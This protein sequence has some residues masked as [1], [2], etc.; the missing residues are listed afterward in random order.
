MQKPDLKRL[1]AIRAAKAELDAA[2]GR[3]ATKRRPRSCSALGRS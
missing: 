1:A 2:K 3:S